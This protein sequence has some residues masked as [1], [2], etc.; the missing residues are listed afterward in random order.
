MPGCWLAAHHHGLVHQLPRLPRQRPKSRLSLAAGSPQGRGP[1]GFCH[2]WEPRLMPSGRLLF[3]VRRKRR[4]A[5]SSLQLLAL[6]QHQRGCH[7][8]PTPGLGAWGWGLGKHPLKLPGEEDGAQYGFPAG[9]AP[10]WH[11]IKMC[12]LESENKAGALI[13]GPRNDHRTA[14]GQVHSIPE[15]SQET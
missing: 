11:S 6:H 13:R 5:S 10:S 8:P 7:R 15:I 1:Q 12:L 3:V 2:C 4:A 9:P 14:L